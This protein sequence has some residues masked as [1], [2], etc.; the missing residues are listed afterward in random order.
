MIEDKSAGYTYD[1]SELRRM[2][3]E[4]P[5][6]PLVV[7]AGENVY[8]DDYAS[9]LC[10]DVRAYI[11]EI[12][13]YDQQVNEEKIYCDRTDFEDDLRIHL[14]DEFDGNDKEFDEFATKKLSE[15]DPYWKK[16]IIVYADN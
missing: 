11:D 16:V 1:T 15:Y 2:I 6:L 4:N 10:A 3:I 9:V 14:E 12:L 8:S 5:D 13:D 7:F